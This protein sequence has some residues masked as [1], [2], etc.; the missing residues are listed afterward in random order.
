MSENDILGLRVEAIASAQQRSRKAF[1]AATVASLVVLVVS[2]NITYSQGASPPGDLSESDKVSLAKQEMKKE[3]A[4]RYFDR[5]YYSLPLVGVQIST[6][7]LVFFA[8]LGLLIFF[9]YYVS[10]MRSTH[11]QLQELHQKF[12]GGSQVA[13]DRER[14]MVVLNSEIVLNTP[15]SELPF[16][17]RSPTFLLIVKLLKTLNLYQLLIFLP[18]VAS[19]AALYAEIHGT[20]FS[21]GALD[22]EGI[23][24]FK[25]LSS[26][27]KIKI[28]CFETLG[29]FVSALVVLYCAAAS[30]YASGAREIVASFT[31]SPDEVR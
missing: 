25:T 20:Y 12:G 11:A 28:V 21:P 6:D 17:M 27:D 7:D 24:F 29:V 5:F 31:T 15:S 1:F 18:A 3:Q 30:R 22:S 13:A 16:K 8:P 2:F 19:A 9:F 4:K 23:P 26:P 14:I 10:C